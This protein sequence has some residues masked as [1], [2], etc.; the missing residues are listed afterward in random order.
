[1]NVFFNYNANNNF[2][3][4]REG[5]NQSGS[6]NMEDIGNGNI[7]FIDMRT[8]AIIGMETV[9]LGIRAHL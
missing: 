3:S 4:E 6:F 1:M 5:V 9:S 8:G 2:I 7:I